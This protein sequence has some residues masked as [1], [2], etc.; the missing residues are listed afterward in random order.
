MQLKLALLLLSQ[1]HSE[2]CAQ[3]VASAKTV[4]EARMGENAGGF[5]D[6]ITEC[7]EMLD[8]CY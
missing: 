3:R 1:G 2:E 5:E 8:R 7:L 4:F 6:E